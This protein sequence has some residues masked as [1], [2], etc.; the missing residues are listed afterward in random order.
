MRALALLLTLAASA[1]LAAS[2]PAPAWK[3]GEPAYATPLR[4][5][6]MA[7]VGAD[8]HPVV[9]RDVPQGTILLRDGRIEAILSAER[10]VPD[11]YRVLD[12]HGLQAWPGYVAV[13]AAGLGLTDDAYAGGVESQMLRGL[14]ESFDPWSDAV[15]LAASAGITTALV[16]RDGGETKGPLA[17]RAAALKMSVREP[18]GC[19]L[20]DMAGALASRAVLAPEARAQ[21]RQAVVKAREDRSADDPRSRLWRAL[22]TRRMPLIATH[23][24]A[25]DLLSLL[26]VA[27][28][29]ELKLL[30]VT[31]V[32]AWPLAE[33]L[34]SQRVAVAQNV[35]YTWGTPRADRRSGLAGGA[36]F[37]AV[38]VLRQAGVPV[39]VVT[40]SPVIVPWG[41]AG[42]DLLDLPLEAAFAVRGGLSEAEAIEAIT[43]DAARLIGQERRVG[44]LEP[45]KDADVVLLDGDPLDYRTLVR[46]TIVNGRVVH[47]AGRSRFWRDIAARRDQALADRR[48]YP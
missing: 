25:G 27:K 30:L 3:P 21:L 11:G 32:E 20:D 40:D 28:D 23:D 39:A 15:E 29:L 8:V 46:Q 36:R 47:D 45:G 5:E 38:H 31:P 43:I 9:G 41:V 12:A 48:Q 22:A 33:R 2:K 19:L 44:S 37:D 26:D 24:A 42:R 10:D 1:P 14:A 4:P 18:R 13:G 16:W 6:P 7:I 35:R 34:A 17:G